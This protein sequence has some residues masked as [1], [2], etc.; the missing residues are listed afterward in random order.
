MAHVT[1]SLSQTRVQDTA[2]GQHLGKRAEVKLANMDCLFLIEASAFAAFQIAEVGFFGHGVSSLFP[3][4]SDE[5]TWFLD[6]GRS[7][8]RTG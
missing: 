2:Q 6:R 8:D 4:K 5:E 1:F 7:C 3:L